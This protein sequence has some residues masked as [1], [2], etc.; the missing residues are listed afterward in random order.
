MTNT[1]N[2][3]DVVDYGRVVVVIFGI[4]EVV[5]ATLFILALVLI[6]RLRSTPWGCL[7]SCYLFTLL[8]C[9][10]R[11]AADAFLYKIHG[12]GYHA[13]GVE[14]AILLTVDGFS[15]VML[16]SI[17]A[18]FIN[19]W[20][21]A[22]YFASSS[23][24]PRFKRFETGLRVAA[25]VWFIVYIVVRITFEALI[26]FMPYSIG[27]TLAIVTNTLYA[28][29][30]M[31][32]CIIAI[33]L[34]FA[35]R[36]LFGRLP[37]RNRRVLRVSAFMAI[38]LITNPFLAA[39]SIWDQAT[40]EPWAHLPPGSFLAFYFGLHVL[41]M[42]LPILLR[43]YPWGNLISGVTDDRVMEEERRKAKAGGM[44]V[45]YLEDEHFK[46][47]TELKRPLREEEIMVSP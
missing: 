32:L 41:V 37:M 26:P 30:I 34:L 46:N 8:F 25:L 43:V 35:L 47:S 13:N 12:G 21:R 7:H 38:F 4:S 27:L 6:I 42:Y 39:M 18:A 11:I 17:D 44:A 28:A 45:S 40:D 31:L 9:V 15:D 29:T 22:V 10:L 33:G 14:S 20:A 23:N 1:T 19:L 5:V 24:E 3:T 16:F 2:I 36:K